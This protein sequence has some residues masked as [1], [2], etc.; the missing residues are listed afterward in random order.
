YLATGL[1]KPGAP[2]YAGSRRATLRPNMGGITE[3][4]ATSGEPV[5]GSTGASGRAGARRGDLVR[6]RLLIAD[7]AGPP[8]VFLV[9]ELVFGRT[10]EPSRL[11]LTEQYLLFVATI[12]GW[13]ALAKLYRLYDHDDER[14]DHSTLDD[15]VGVFHL[16]TVGAWL[17]AV[18]T[19]ASGAA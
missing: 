19:W 10:S 5:A 2:L 13:F 4:T 18:V 9:A 8:L 16:A 3:T 14:T 17:G 15:L 1:R 11:S 7:A 12:P 6:R